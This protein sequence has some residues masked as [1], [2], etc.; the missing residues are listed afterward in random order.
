[1]EPTKMPPPC[2]GAVAPA[3]L[4]Q[5]VQTKPGSTSDSLIA[6]APKNAPKSTFG[7]FGEPEIAAYTIDFTMENLVGAPGLE[8]GP[9]D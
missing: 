7:G 2:C 3:R 4:L 8:P 6:T 1:M 9:A 5:A